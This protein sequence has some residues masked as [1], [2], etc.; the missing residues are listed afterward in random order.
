MSFYSL[1]PYSVTPTSCTECVHSGS[2]L[3]GQSLAPAANLSLPWWTVPLLRRPTVSQRE[4]LSSP[5]CFC[6]GENAERTPQATTPG[7]GAFRS[8]PSPSG[9]TRAPEGQFPQVRL[10]CHFPGGSS[11]P[12]ARRDTAGP[13]SSAPGRTHNSTALGPFLRPEKCMK[14]TLVAHSRHRICSEQTS[15]VHRL[16]IYSTRSNITAPDSRCNTLSTNGKNSLDFY[17]LFPVCSWWTPWLWNL[18]L[19]GGHLLSTASPVSVYHSV[20]YV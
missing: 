9:Q 16:I 2:Q 12:P 11:D 18:L 13:A 19:L 3:A 8:C 5:S 1:A 17:H 20:W 7:E 15:S 10:K 4:P 14:Q 6:Q